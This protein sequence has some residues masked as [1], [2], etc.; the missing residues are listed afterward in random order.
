MSIP[1]APYRADFFVHPDHSRLAGETITPQVEQ[2]EA[3]LRARIDGSELPILVYDPSQTVQ[4][5]DFWDRFP[6]GQRFPTIPGRGMLASDRAT[7]SRLNGLLDE[8]Q[9][10][11]GLVH[12]SYL[13]QCVQAF[14]AGLMASARN[15]V[16]YY[17]SVYDI[18]EA[19]DTLHPPTVKFGIVLR[20]LARGNLSPRF[21]HSGPNLPPEYAAD[22][23]IFDL[24]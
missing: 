11:E 3:A 13:A 8:R 12:G 5:G 7:H 10:V 9:V 1:A 19:W 17:R 16:L 15:G 14:Q 4:A 6:K 23:R 21:R 18:G 22:A 20:S 2:Y 24:T